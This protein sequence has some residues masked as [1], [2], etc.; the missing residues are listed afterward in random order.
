MKFYAFLFAALLLSTP[1][2]AEPTSSG[3]ESAPEE[4]HG[5]DGSHEAEQDAAPGKGHGK[6]HGSSRLSDVAIPLADLPD[7]PKPLVELGEPFLGTGTLK[8][9]IELPTGAV[10]QPSLLLFGNLRLAAQSFEPDDGL[11][12]I[13]EVAARLDL[14]ANLQLSGSERLVVGIRA[15]DGGGQ[16]TS[17]FL[18]HPD[19]DLDGKFRDTLD[20]D[21]EVL[22]FEGD[23][24]EIFPDLDRDD[25]GSLDIGFSVG[26]Q[27]MLFQEG[28]LINDTIDGIGLTRN[29]LL[30]GNSSNFRLT[31]FYGWGN[32][33]SSFGA[34]RDGE[35]FALLSSTDLRKST[36]DVDVAYL[37]TDD[38]S[39]DLVAGGL[40]AVQR[41]GRTNSS[42]RLL[43]SR[44]VDEETALAGDGFLLF[45]ELSWV[46]HGTHDLVYFNSFWA[47][48]RYTPVARGVGGAGGGPLGRAGINFASVDIGSFDAPLS[49]RAHDVVGGAVGYQRFFD[50]TRKQLLLELG[51]RFGTRGDEGDDAQAATL[52]YQAA[53]GQR[54]VWVF[55]AFV[56]RREL[57]GGGD[58]VPYGGRVE[59]VVKF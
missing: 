10:W 18:E 54:L 12:R 45:N 48:D 5:H 26:R 8:P 43:A 1:V 20:A 41:L 39:G 46:P 56:A 34:E 36:L 25:F 15:T 13:S 50:H 21:L 22:F 3:G 4:T 55:D 27:Q 23:F 59:L 51:F 35:L 44:T 31:A 14:F 7:R 32:L 2:L 37:S 11:G 24:G 17:Y 38:G 57:L 40:S 28:L 19:P 58:E 16:F 6:G 47:V 52:R 30:P 42:F 49:S 9:G 29:T 53:Q 33:D